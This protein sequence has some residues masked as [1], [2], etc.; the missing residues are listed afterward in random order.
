MSRLF[1]VCFAG[2]SGS[3]TADASALGSMI[4]PAMKKNG[5]DADYAVA[6][7][8]SSTRSDQSFRQVS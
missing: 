2:I 7:N 5:F 1:L 6:V 3:A 4:I 8:A